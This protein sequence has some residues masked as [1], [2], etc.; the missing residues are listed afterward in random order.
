MP[1]KPEVPNADGSIFGS[2]AALP[3]RETPKRFV[4]L[5]NPKTEPDNRQKK[6]TYKIASKRKEYRARHHTPEPA[7]SIPVQKKG[8]PVDLASVPGEYLEG[9]DKNSPDQWNSR[10]SAA[11]ESGAEFVNDHVNEEELMR[12]YDEYGFVTDND[13]EL[14][15]KEH[16]REVKWR[17]MIFPDG[18]V[19]TSNIHRRNKYWENVIKRKWK[20]KLKTRVRKGIPNV[21]RGEAWV[22]LSGARRARI[23]QPDVY[24][25]LLQ[26]LDRCRFTA[27][28]WKDIRRSY[29]SHSVFEEDDSATQE[30]LFNVLA[31]YSLYNSSMGY[32]QAESFVC[33]LLLLYMEEED[34]FWT[35]HV[36]ATDPKY[37]MEGVWS[38]EMPLVPVRFDQFKYFLKKF[39][40]A[41]HAKLEENN[42]IPGMY[43]AT[44]WF[45][46]VFLATQLPHSTKL[47]I[48]DVFLH[49]GIKA[50]FRIGLAMIK[51]KKTDIL[52]AP[53]E[54]SLLLTLKSND[55]D[56]E[57]LI[58]DSCKIPI[59]R[60]Q[61]VQQDYKHSVE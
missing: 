40:P 11:S 36:L 16:E 26:N 8:K 60:K 34:V 10:G 1:F 5:S 17:K 50:I 22:H 18:R 58:E 21:F 38:R 51:I 24:K 15:M 42:I 27:Q 25:Q 47:R 44:Q 61:I 6:A 39:E 9:A 29:R 13:Y 54:L 43:E 46:T 37:A 53:D 30:A 45:L 52:K 3:A 2:I 55:S 32:N 23:N 4:G 33:S 28:I 19:A 56:Y 20:N 7:E 48:W 57:K 49:D 35:L 41:I 12:Y 14:D 59:T 31:A